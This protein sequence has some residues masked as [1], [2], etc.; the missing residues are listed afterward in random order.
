MVAMGTHAWKG[1]AHFFIGS[2]AEDVAN[3]LTIPIWTL[4]LK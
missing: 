3:H 1:L 4:C 2:I